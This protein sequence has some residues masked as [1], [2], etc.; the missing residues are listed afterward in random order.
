MAGHTADADT[1]AVTVAGAAAGVAAVKVAG[2][3][4]K[5]TTVTVAG[6]ATLVLALAALP[7]R[8]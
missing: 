7:W 2:E 8:W 4:R 1:N 6:A 5:Q 3:A